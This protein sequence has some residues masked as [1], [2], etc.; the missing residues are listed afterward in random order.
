[1]KKLRTYLIVLLSAAFVMACAVVAL[2]YFWSIDGSDTERLLASAGQEM[3]KPG[4][5]A[6][7]YAQ[8][9]SFLAILTKSET[10]EMVLTLFEEDSIFPNR[11][12]H[13]GGGYGTSHYSTY[14]LEMGKDGGDFQLYVV[15]GENFDQR[16]AYYRLEIGGEDYSAPIDGAYFL[17]VHELKNPVKPGFEFRVFD[18]SGTELNGNF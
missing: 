16:A 17:A 2:H 15:Y 1:M 9:E 18:A 14:I 3:D 10:E 4:L 12:R 13:T 5:R 11:Y 7:R 6:V 8:S